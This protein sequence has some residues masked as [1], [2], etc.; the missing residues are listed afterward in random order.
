VSPLVSRVCHRSGRDLFLYNALAPFYLYAQTF[1]KHYSNAVF[2][3]NIVIFFWYAY[4]LLGATE[5]TKM[6]FSQIPITAGCLY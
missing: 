4:C 2:L 3:L 6:A 1:K 5:I